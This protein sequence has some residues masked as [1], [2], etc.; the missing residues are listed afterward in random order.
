MPVYTYP[1]GISFTHG[2][3]DKRGNIK[4]PVI[5]LPHAKDL[6]VEE[7]EA[8]KKDLQ[9]AQ[10]VVRCLIKELRQT[11]TSPFIRLLVSNDNAFK[12]AVST[13]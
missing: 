7:A 13:H 4:R 5:T 6:T 9:K 2:E 8:L 3:R 11:N 12:P 1:S 10:G